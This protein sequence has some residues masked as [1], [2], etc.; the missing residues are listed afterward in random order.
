MCDNFIINSVFQLI[1]LTA[2][3][4]VEPIMSNIRIKIKK[5]DMDW[6]QV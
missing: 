1:K 2:F 3:T 6:K 4:S 5:H